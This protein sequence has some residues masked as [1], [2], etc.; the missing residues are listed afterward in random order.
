MAFE[1]GS[2][3]RCGQSNC[4]QCKSAK[5]SVVVS[6]CTALRVGDG[7]SADDTIRRIDSYDAT[8][9]PVV[10]KSTTYTNVTTGLDL[11]S[12]PLMANLDCTGCCT[13]KSKIVRTFFKQLT[14]VYSLQDA[15]TETS[16]TKI[17]SF[18]Y[19]QMDGIGSVEGDIGFPIP[20][21]RGETWS[22]A[23]GSAENID[24]LSTGV[25]FDPGFNGIGRLMI[26][27]IV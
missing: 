8:C 26:H 13:P 25:S 21:D 1:S 7:Y 20:I 18:T 11:T 9:L 10:L 12:T 15:K 24:S 23:S 27:F 4:R 22:G 2:T 6:Q 14:N 17:I 19:K 5:L 16:A 3:C